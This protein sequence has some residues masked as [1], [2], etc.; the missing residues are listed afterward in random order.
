MKRASTAFF[1]CLAG[2]ACFC[3]AAGRPAAAATDSA[4]YQVRFDATWSAGSHPIDF[5]PGAHFS[6]LIGG[7]HGAGASFWRPGELASAGIRDMAERGRTSPL[8]A[9]VAAA[10]AAGQ[11]LE[12]IR[13]GA[14]SPSPGSAT[15]NFGIH[16]DFPLV[17]LVTMIAPSPDWFVGVY[18]LSLF[19]NGDWVEQ[20]KIA[21]YGWDA[22]T[23]DGPDFTSPNAASQPPQP[24][25]LLA[26]GSFANGVPLGTFTFTRQGG[27]PPQQLSLGAGRF[28]VELE[29]ED[30]QGTRARGL[31]VVLTADS[32]YFY[33]FNPENVELVIKVLN[34]CAI[35]QH[36]WVFAG[37]LTDVGVEIK[38]IDTV[39]GLERPYGNQLGQAF[40][41]IRD[42]SAFPCG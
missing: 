29:Y 9:E 15:A 25:A 33:F 34:G 21:L 37:G 41:P 2:L 13:G 42:S 6:S 3:L 4:Q 16:R 23:D 14:V 10:I 1:A 7:V 31:P 27:P 39:T 32:G 18:G 24:I 28:R 40:A 30:Y 26:S 36:Y 20:K 12:V 11:A 5:P 22:G 8:D 35:N 19:E 17:S 38:V